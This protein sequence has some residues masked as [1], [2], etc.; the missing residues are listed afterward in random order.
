M[1]M[2]AFCMLRYNTLRPTKEEDRLVAL[3]GIASTMKSRVGGDYFAGLWKTQ[4][5]L[6]FI[7]QLCWRAELQYYHRVYNKLYLGEV[8][9]GAI[10][11]KASVLRPVVVL[12]V[13]FW[14]AQLQSQRLLFGRAAPRSLGHRHRPGAVRSNGRGPQRDLARQGTAGGG[15]DHLGVGAKA[16]AALTHNPALRDKRE[17]DLR[18]CCLPRRL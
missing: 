6:D 3:G 8:S 16:M 4:D 11:P 15:A 1:G 12:A 18:D 14:C 7:K 13:C 9:H 5:P 2:E 10:P 17:R